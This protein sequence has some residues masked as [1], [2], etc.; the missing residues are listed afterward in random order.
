MQVAQLLDQ[1]FE[2]L[3]SRRAANIAE[4]RAQN[5]L[6]KIE[7][8]ALHGEIARFAVDQPPEVQACIKQATTRGEAGNCLPPVPLT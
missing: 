1:G 4:L 3:A 8:R 7:N 2:D 5:S 6:L